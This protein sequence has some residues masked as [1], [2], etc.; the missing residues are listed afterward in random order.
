MNADPTA[1]PSLPKV[2]F[3]LVLGLFAGFG[4]AFPEVSR[5]SLLLLDLLGGLGTSSLVAIVG[6]LVLVPLM[7]GLFVLWR[8]IK[9]TT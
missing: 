4:L 5:Q 2:A 8:A 6:S 7:M 1:D 3:S 9:G